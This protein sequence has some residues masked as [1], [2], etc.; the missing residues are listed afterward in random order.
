M[1]GVVWGDMDAVFDL[2]V[3]LNAAYFSFRHGAVTIHG[4]HVA[5]VRRL[6]ETRDSLDEKVSDEDVVRVEMLVKQSDDFDAD[7]HKAYS[8]ADP[9]LLTTGYSTCI[10]YAVLLF[11]AATNHTEKLSYGTALALFVV[12]FASVFISL[13]LEIR[14]TVRSGRLYWRTHRLYKKIMRTCT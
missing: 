7:M 12:G 8:G 4:R 14:F 3:V 1:E 9:V 6:E 13:V 5:E 11:Y 2:A 10:L